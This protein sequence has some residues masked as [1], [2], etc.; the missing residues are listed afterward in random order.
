RASL[1]LVHEGDT[2]VCLTDPPLLGTSLGEHLR[3]R[4][5]RIW[6]WNQD[7][8]PE[9]AIGI[10]D[11]AITRLM[12]ARLKAARDREW[13]ACTG[14]TVPGK[15]MRDLVLSRGIDPHKVVVTPNW[16][17]KP[18]DPAESGNLRE[19]WGLEDKFVVGY[20]GNLGR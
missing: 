3:K 10:Y 9:V 7:I 6:H 2:V 4:R 20:A 15:D 14:I 1:G 19:A 17:P 12:L 5:A 16:A 8:Y 13:R 11:K 18:H